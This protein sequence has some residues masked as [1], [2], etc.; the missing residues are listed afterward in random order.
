[1]PTIV[2]TIPL[3]CLPFVPCGNRPRKPSARIR[4][5]LPT[6]VHGAAGHLKQPAANRV[7]IVEDQA[8][9]FSTVGKCNMRSRN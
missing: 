1:V 9:H 3:I 5:R 7:H 8:L 4:Q 6:S 2:E